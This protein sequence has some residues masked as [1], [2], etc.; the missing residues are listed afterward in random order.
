MRRLLPIA[1][2]LLSSAA[3]AQTT[4]DITVPGGQVCSYA[5]GSVSNGSAPG[6]LQ[7]TA[8]SSTGAGCGTGGSGNV[9]FGPAT[10]VAATPVSVYNGTSAVTFQALNA[11][12]C[13]GSVT[14]NSGSF[15][16]GTTLCNSATTCANPIT[17]TAK[18][19]NEG[20]QAQNYTISVSCTGT[21]GSAS[22]Q[23]IVS[24]PFNGGGGGDTS[25]FS[26]A[27]QSVPS[28]PFQRATGTI[29]TFRPG[30]GTVS[31]DA[32]SF[33]AIFG[34]SDSPT[35][36][37]S[38]GLT[39]NIYLPTNRYVALAF[40]VP[41][42]FFETAPNN[43]GVYGIYSLNAS[44]FTVPASMSISTKCG[45]FSPPGGA[46]STVC[47]KSNMVSDAHFVWTSTTGSSCQLRSGQPYF[48]NIINAKV[49]N[50][51]A[52]G[53]G[54]ATST[55]NIAK[56]PA[57]ICVDTPTNLGGTWVYPK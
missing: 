42:R 19:D 17:A 21:G 53:G 10:P 46:S 15:V 4:L 40:T 52:N 1:L 41:Q 30:A 23:A 7:A 34:T 32:T 43:T 36:P 3:F 5:T 6:H 24:V 51:T 33:D 8:T 16:G 45:D 37:G 26:I 57:S 31:R 28:S 27:N 35:W 49:E 9:T 2:T 22:S 39:T 25:C 48:L 55:S 47:V 12:S 38:Y 54:S 18:F 13:T 20:T 14:P 29:Q 11:N 44:Q 56:C 50:V